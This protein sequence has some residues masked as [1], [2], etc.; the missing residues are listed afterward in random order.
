MHQ[1]AR[2]TDD[3]KSQEELGDADRQHPDGRRDDMIGHTAL[4]SI[5]REHLCKLIVVSFAACVSRLVAVTLRMERM[6]RHTGTEKC[7]WLIPGVLCVLN[8]DGSIRATSHNAI[9][10]PINIHQGKQAIR[11]SAPGWG[12]PSQDA[13]LPTWKGRLPGTRH[14]VTRPSTGCTA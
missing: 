7:H 5:R 10:Q 3:D 13:C 6:G 11:H 8:Q 2:Q 4:L 14:A 9:P 1:S 12:L